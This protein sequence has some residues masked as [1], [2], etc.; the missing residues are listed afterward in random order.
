MAEKK[1]P[2]ISIGIIS[3]TVI[4]CVLCLTVFSVLT[5]STALSEREL[6]KKRAE[7]AEEYYRAEREA[8]KLANGLMTSTDAFAFAEKNQID[9]RSEEEKEIFSYIL[10]IDEGQAISAELT[11]T[12]TWNVTRW[13]V[14]STADWTLDESITVWD[15]EMLSDE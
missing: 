9:V 7:A 4:L 10:P 11:Y 3:M 14:I 2:K 5:L 13:Q 15:G 6:S 1:T 8:A 12:E